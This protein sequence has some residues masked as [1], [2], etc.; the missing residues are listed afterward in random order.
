MT[1][2]KFRLK[3]V[4]AALAGNMGLPSA[5]VREFCYLQLRMS[6]ELMALSCVIAHDSLTEAA[7]RKL[8]KEYHA[9]KIMAVLAGLHPDFFPKHINIAF[10]VSPHHHEL[11][12]VE[13]EGMTRERLGVL[14]ARCGA[15][16][17]RGS[18]SA[19]MKGRQFQIEKEYA[20]IR[21]ELAM[22]RRLLAGCALRSVDHSYT[23]ICAV[24]WTN[25]E[26][27]QIRYAVAK[28]YI[29]EWPHGGG[30]SQ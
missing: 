8:L 11:V 5:L 29:G 3:A 20:D 4:D 27:A 7:A 17:H 1:E 26:P 12:D 22:F 24:S 14:Y 16:L 23:L 30:E 13:Q 6:C 2:L 25:D 18:A 21:L 9:G 10:N 28:T 15:A 19:F